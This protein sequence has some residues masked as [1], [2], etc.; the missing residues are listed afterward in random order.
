MSRSLVKLKP[1]C[2]AC[3]M[4]LNV[5][6]TATHSAKVPKRRVQVPLDTLDAEVLYGK[7]EVSAYRATN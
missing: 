7:P 5:S 4:A 3:L 2:R 1:L 6:T